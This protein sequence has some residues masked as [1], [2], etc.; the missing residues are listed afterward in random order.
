MRV[1]NF[2]AGPAGLPLPALEQARDEL[3]DFQGSGAS[4]MEVSHRGKVYEAVHDEASALLK[5]LLK[6]PDTHQ[7]LWLQGGATTHFG[8]IALNFLRPGAFAQYVVTGVW[9]EKALAE[10]KFLGDARALVDTRSAQ[11]KYVRLPNPSEL[12]PAPQ[13]AYVHTTSNETVDGVQFATLPRFGAVPHVCD[14]SSD[15]LARPFEVEPFDLIY[16]GAQKNLGPSGVVALI[17]RKA[18]LQSGRTDLPKIFRYAAHAEANSLLNTPPTF[19]IYLCRNVLQWLVAQGGLA[20]IEARNRAKADLV[21]RA[22]DANPGFFRTAVAHEARSMMN[23]VFHLPSEALDAQFVQEA[24]A[25]GMIGLKGHKVVGGLRVSAYN[26]V[27]V[28]DVKV[29]VTFM[30]EFVKRHG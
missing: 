27:S 13:A 5:S 3:L 7:V 21:Y 15:F 30:N 25:A 20:A 29:L 17:A 1:I 26:A 28:D 18:F 4:I 24:T 22:L 9:G 16:A 8:M 6:V 11:G 14:M 10:A 23:I 12:V 19:S 2:S